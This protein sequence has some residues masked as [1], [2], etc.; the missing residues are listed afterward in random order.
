VLLTDAGEALLNHARAIARDFERLREDMRARKGE[1]TGRVIFGIPPT[2]ADTL[3][4]RLVEAARRQFPLITL[5]VAEGL[6]PVLAGWLRGGDVDVAVLSLAHANDTED[7]EGIALEA[8]ASEDMVVVEKAGMPRPPAIYERN[9]LSEKPVV[10]S[11]MLA[12]IV[13]R[14]LGESDLPLRVMTEIDSVQAARTM[15]L[16]GQAATILPISMLAN[17]LSRGEV[18]VSAI[19]STPVR[20]T[21]ALAVPNFRP[22]TQASEAM[23]RLSR[24]L[25]GQMLAEGLFSTPPAES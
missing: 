11:Q 18:I 19:T 8:I 14:Q 10:V 12:N 24:D 5:K 25:V 21:L 17:E 2:L 7:M 6:T 3:V 4:P 15:A 22:A 13:R 1:P 16:L 9:A 20:R 23:R